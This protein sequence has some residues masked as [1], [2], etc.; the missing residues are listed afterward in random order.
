[1]NFITKVTCS[2]VLFL[3]MFNNRFLKVFLSSNKHI[4]VPWKKCNKYF[5]NIFTRKHDD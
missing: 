4:E 1:M 2:R 5:Y 3:F